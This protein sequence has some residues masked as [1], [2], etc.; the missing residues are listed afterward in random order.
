[1]FA[2]SAARMPHRQSKHIGKENSAAVSFTLF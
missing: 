2:Q 1:M